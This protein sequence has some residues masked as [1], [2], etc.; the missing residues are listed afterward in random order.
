MQDR[1][2]DRRRELNRRDEKPRLEFLQ[3]VVRL[4]IHPKGLRCAEIAG[5]AQ[6]RVGRDGPLAVNDL[7][8]APGRR[9]HSPPMESIAA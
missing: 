3:V 5:Q 2:D 6:G 4:E 9:A 7:V 1:A 8:D